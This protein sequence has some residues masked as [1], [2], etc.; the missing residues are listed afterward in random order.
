MQRIRFGMLGL[1]FGRHIVDSLTTGPAR[2]VIDLAQV[3]DRDRDRAHAIGDRLHLP[4]AYDLDEL[5]ADDS[6]EAIGVFTGPAG[7]AEMIRKIIRAG[8]HVMTT[9]PFEVNSE[10]ALDVLEEA[11]YLGKVVHLNSPSPLMPPNLQQAFKWQKQYELG[12]PVACRRDVWASYREKADGTWMDDPKLCPVA[13]M[14]RLG[15]YLVN[16]MIRLLGEVET[17][18]VTHSRVFTGR[19]TADNAQLTLQFRSGSIGS[20]FASFCVDDNRP[21]G[22]AMTL[23]YERGTIYQNVNPCSIEQLNERRMTLVTTAGRKPVL[24]HVTLDTDSGQYQWDVFSRAIRGEKLEDAVT[25]KQ[26]VAG[27]RVVEAMSRAAESG[28]TERVESV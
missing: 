3:C 4:T 18:Q 27:L 22:N 20:I 1:N 19:P 8:K 26:V 16:D 2:N 7:R 23:N 13:P 25:P 6:L 28:R 10:A 9:K 12:R 24:E 21:Y 14:F 15:I 17:V 5:L 11:N